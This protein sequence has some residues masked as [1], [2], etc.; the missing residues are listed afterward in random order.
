MSAQH[1]IRCQRRHGDSAVAGFR[2]LTLTG[3]HNAGAVFQLTL[4]LHT[5]LG[6]G[7]HRAGADPR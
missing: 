6:S 7:P 1:R 5:A 4:A 3:P 2:R